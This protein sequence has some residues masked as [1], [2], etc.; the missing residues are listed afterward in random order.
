[1]FNIKVPVEVPRNTFWYDNVLQSEAALQILII[2]SEEYAAIDCNDHIEPNQRMIDVPDLED[3]QVAD[4]HPVYNAN[5][6]HIR[7]DEAEC[8]YCPFIKYK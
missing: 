4:A 5:V 1:M 2:Q 8:S 6:E 7:E 3:D